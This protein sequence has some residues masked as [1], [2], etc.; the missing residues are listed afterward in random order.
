MAGAT[1]QR[2]RTGG[3]ESEEMV[4]DKEQDGE[5][6]SGAVCSKKCTAFIILFLPTHSHYVH[7]QSF[8][9]PRLVIQTE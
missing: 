4:V 9:V 3:G 6:D 7:R 2:W 8:R 5:R 1:G